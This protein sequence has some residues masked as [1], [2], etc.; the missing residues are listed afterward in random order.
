MRRKDKEIKGMAEIEA[1]IERSM[2]CRLALADEN[3]PYIVPMCF[4][5]N[6]KTLYFHTANK[7]KKLEILKKNNFV[8]FEFDIDYEPIK[9]DKA[10]DWTMKYK[11][12]IGYG[13]ALFIEEFESKCHALDIILQ[14]YSNK[15]FIYPE[16][17]V[18]NTT[19]I[20]VEIE[21]MTGKM[22][23]WGGLVS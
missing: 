23:G 20:K 10:C 19:V 3:R 21:H 2:V 4:G 1:I 11:S 8:C 9:A 18:K 7:G 5:Y 15:K 6:N 13:K 16:A 17:N 22:S 12:V 14:N